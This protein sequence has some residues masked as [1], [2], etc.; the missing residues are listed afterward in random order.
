[1]RRA[2]LVCQGLA[3]LNSLFLAGVALAALWL[4]D[5]PV[6]PLAALIDGLYVAVGH[7]SSLRL[8]RREHQ[9]GGCVSLPTGT[10]TDPGESG[11]RAA[12]AHLAGAPPQPV[13]VDGL[14]LVHRLGG[15]LY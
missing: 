2:E 5:H 13:L 7:V 15:E 1:M 6:H 11:K 14:E 8:R 4:S 9:W 12:L 10:A 3:L